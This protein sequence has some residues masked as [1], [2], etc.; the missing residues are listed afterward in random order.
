MS[1]A[2]RALR[3]C[4]PALPAPPLR[5]PALP[6]RLRSQHSGPGPVGPH[7]L[8]TDLKGLAAQVVEL[9]AAGGVPAAVVQDVSA[10]LQERAAAPGQPPD[11]AAQLLP[12]FEDIPAASRE[13]VVPILSA[14]THLLSK[15][16]ALPVDNPGPTAWAPPP[17]LKRSLGQTETPIPAAERLQSP[18]KRH[19]ETEVLIVGAAAAG[20]SAGACLQQEG[21]P[22]ILLDQDSMVGGVWEKRYQRLHLHDI[23][24]SCHLP[25]LPMPDTYPVYPSRMQFVQYLQSYQKMMNLDVRLH[26]RVVSASKT[27]DGRWEVKVL[28]TERDDVVTYRCRALVVANGM[29]TKPRVPEFPG[30]SDF[31]GPIVHSS[32]YCTGALYAGHRVLVVG[33]GN[34]GAEIVCDLWEHGA[35]PTVLQRSPSPILPR[36]LVG[37]S[38]QLMYRSPFWQ[39]MMQHGDLFWKVMDL[40][41]QWIVQREFGD[42]QALGLRVSRM[43]PIK[44]WRDMFSAPCMDVGTVQLVRSGAVPVVNEEIERFTP[45]GVLLKGRQEELPFDAVV[46]ATGYHMVGAHADWLSPELCRV[47]GSGWDF[48]REERVGRGALAHVAGGPCPVPDLY[49]M[50]G[51]LLMIRESA[52]SMAKSIKASL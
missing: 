34:S 3:R 22:C 48:I 13:V 41:H 17:A 15:H 51:N 29:F 33:M 35:K 40:V 28:N 27:P 5:R 46:L 4:L 12:Y 20:L 14:A 1:V 11:G 21:V 23:I 52:P 42:L 38:Q 45:T 50:W 9:L 7:G 49:F 10:T 44:G 36:W 24:D 8:P 37:V 6:R 25:Y 47:L 2:V 16:L 32:Q 39:P 19:T 31:S 26:S 18:A 43:P 30:Q